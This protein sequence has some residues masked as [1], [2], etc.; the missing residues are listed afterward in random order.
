MEADH[1]DQR[2]R[3]RLAA[4]VGRRLR[5]STVQLSLLNHQVAASTG[6]QHVDLLCLDLISRSEP[7]TAGGLARRAGLHPATVTGVLDRLEKAGW[8]RRERVSTDRRAVRIRFEP[9]RV[10]DI[11]GLYGPM[12]RSVEAICADFDA[13][14]LQAVALFLARIAEAGRDATEDLSR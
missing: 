9:G 6:L 2:A 8:I 3:H 13:E 12:L 1:D 5:H 10:G 11:M 14:Q 7:L 4:D